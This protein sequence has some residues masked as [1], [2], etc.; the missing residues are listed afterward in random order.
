[1]ENSNTSFI[2]S[3]AVPQEFFAR[4]KI[5]IYKELHIKELLTKEQLDA[6]IILQKACVFPMEI[7]K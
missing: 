6:L 4:L 3:S 1:M 7:K 5:G 2:C